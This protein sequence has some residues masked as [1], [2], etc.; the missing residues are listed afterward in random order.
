MIKVLSSFGIFLYSSLIT[1]TV[2]RQIQIH[3]IQ[4][5]SRFLNFSI[6][7]FVF[8]SFIVIVLKSSNPLLKLYKMASQFEAVLATASAIATSNSS[9]NNSSVHASSHELTNPNNISLS[10]EATTASILTSFLNNTINSLINEFSNNITSDLNASTIVNNTLNGRNFS[11]TT[12]P[13]PSSISTTLPSWSCPNSTIAVLTNTTENNAS[14]LYPDPDNSTLI[15]MMAP[16]ELCLTV[17]PLSLISLAIIFGNLLV[18]AA[19]FTQKSL[20]SPQN[21]YIVSLALADMGVGVFILPYTITYLVLRRWPFGNFFCKVWLTSDVALCCVS[22][23]HLCA[24]G[25]DRF[26]AITDGINYVQKRNLKS[27]LWTIIVIWILAIWVGS[28]LVLAV[29]DWKVN[30][31]G[32]D[33]LMPTSVGFHFHLA[34]GGLAF[35]LIIMSVIYVKIYYA[36]KQRLQE[37]ARV[38]CIELASDA[39]TTDRLDSEAGSQTTE[40]NLN[41]GNTNTLSVPVKRSERHKRK[42]SAQIS[43]FLVNKQ[44]FSLSRER[45][46]ART[47]GIIMGAF[48]ICWLPLGFLNVV[49]A[50]MPPGHKPSEVI[51]HTLSW[52]GYINSGLNPIIY[53][54]SNQEFQKAFRRVLH[55]G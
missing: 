55:I 40:D 31:D 46:A 10:L 51:Y 35:P 4:F 25:V 28:P 29:N 38:T 13:T 49:G 37:R 44:K 41:D 27:V 2:L 6:R 45:K 50:L 34:I 24:I 17:I 21:I 30:Y 7:S 8:T 16:V 52:L 26:R 18:I 9:F 5:L 54:I 22:I 33:C 39:D 15:P 53:A 20:R 12:T 19:V 1:N 42:P 32:N 3:N 36:I 47:L 11:F 23:F 43:N 14:I 48:I